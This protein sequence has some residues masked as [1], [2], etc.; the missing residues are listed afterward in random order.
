MV[1]RSNSEAN[2]SANA[3]WTSLAQ[4]VREDSQLTRLPTHDNNFGELVTKEAL[5]IPGF[6]DLPSEIFVE[7][8][9]YLIRKKATLRDLATMNKRSSMLAPNSTHGT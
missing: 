4:P 9:K 8:F 6:Q 1:T 5:A 7:V 3:R 2:S